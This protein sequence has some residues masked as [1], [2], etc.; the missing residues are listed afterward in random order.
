MAQW[1]ALALV[2]VKDS[3]RGG[4]VYPLVDMWIKL[5]VDHGYEIVDRVDPTCPGWRFGTNHA[6]RTDTET[7]L[8]A[9][10]RRQL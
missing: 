2:N 4:A 5:L 9:Q 3:T 7:V 1:P 10:S 6:A 8:V